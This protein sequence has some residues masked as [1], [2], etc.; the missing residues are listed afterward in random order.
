MYIA[1][2]CWTFDITCQTWAIRCWVSWMWRRTQ[3]QQ[4]GGAEAR[5]RR[6]VVVC[7]VKHH[8][9]MLCSM[10]WYTVCTNRQATTVQQRHIPHCSTAFSCIVTVRFWCHQSPKLQNSRK[11]AS[12][13]SRGTTAMCVANCA[14]G[15]VVVVAARALTI[16]GFERQRRALGIAT[17]EPACVVMVPTVTTEPT[18]PV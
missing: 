17:F 9:D 15:I 13:R 3:W 1:V 12:I 2:L 10:Y 7:C 11:K 8:E 14:V 16:T 6:G 5:T 18:P 4:R